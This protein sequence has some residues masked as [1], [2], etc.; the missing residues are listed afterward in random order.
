MTLEL[1]VERASMD[2]MDQ[3]Q[4]EQYIQQKT[5]Q[6]PGLSHLS[7]EQIWEILN[8]TRD[9][10]PTMAAVMNFCICPQGYFPQLGVAAAAISDGEMG[11]AAKENDRV[12]A[13][14][15]IEGTIPVMV[16][17]ALD[18]CEENA[19]GD[20]PP[21]ALQ[22][23]ILN[24][25]IH[26]DYSHQTEGTPVQIT[27]YTDRI[28]I[29]SPGSLYGYADTSELKG[30]KPLLRNPALASMAKTLT[31]NHLSPFGISSMCQAMEARGLPAPVF[32]NHRDEFVVTLYNRKGLLAGRAIDGALPRT[33][34]TGTP[35]ENLL[36]F[37]RT[38]RSRKEIAD[39][40][41][42]NTIFYVMAHY[43]T[44]LVEKGLLGMTIP[45]K[46]KS[47][48]QKYFTID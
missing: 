8:L 48:N 6:H 27:I 28:E 12:L 42:I 10:V 30:A 31:E 1:T 13:S 24:A 16:K 9:N 11:A 20:Y 35:A 7:K 22:E 26:R 37:C 38:A 2:M 14:T 21:G 18:F 29:R 47:R 4:L 43:V 17:K 23:G 41:G 25:L 46:P 40:L 19:G 15:Q 33:Y 34:G 45:D 36:E 3:D 5:L 39:F 44:P 32:E